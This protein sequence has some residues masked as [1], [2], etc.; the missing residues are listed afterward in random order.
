MITR[1]IRDDEEDKNIDYNQPSKED[2]GKILAKK[3]NDK[4]YKEYVIV[5]LSKYETGQYHLKS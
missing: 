1:F 4:L 3:Y 5:D 2:Y